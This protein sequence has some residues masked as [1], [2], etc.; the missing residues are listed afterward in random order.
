MS[1]ELLIDLCSPT[2][3]GLKTASLV[4]VE[5]KDEESVRDDLRNLNGQFVKK[6]L[7]AVPL[8][9]KDGHALIYIYRPEQLQRDINKGRAAALLSERGYRT[10]STARCVAHLAKRINVE[11]DFPHEIGFFLGYPSEDVEG[12]IENL[13]RNCKACGF[14]K[15]YGDVDSAERKFSLCRKCCNIYK[16]CWR[17]GRSIDDLTV[18]TQSPVA[19][20]N[21]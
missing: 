2:L 5:Y 13:G 18:R 1:E 4:N 6:G 21:S 16:K 19:A 17:S 7:C 15:V 3:A 14:W 8:K 11:N 12:F 9:Y 20:I 10:S